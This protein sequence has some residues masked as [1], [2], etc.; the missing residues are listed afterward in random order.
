MLYLLISILLLCSKDSFAQFTLSGSIYD[1]ESSVALRNCKLIFYEGQRYLG[2]C[3]TD[4][5]GNFSKSLQNCKAIHLKIFSEEFAI[6]E[7]LNIPTDEAEINLNIGLRFR[8][9]TKDQNQKENVSMVYNPSMKDPINR[10]MQNLARL[11]KLQISILQDAYEYSKIEL[12]NK[13][14]IPFLEDSK[15]A[16]HY[17]QQFK[18]ME[19]QNDRFPY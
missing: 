15:R 4:A 1:H 6:H 3:R 14:P 7:I 8:S 12:S 11:D 17:N 13:G 10:R 16:T 18:A 19:K 2:K 5:Y 9:D